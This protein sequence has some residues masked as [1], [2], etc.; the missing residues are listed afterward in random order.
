VLDPF[1]NEYGQRLYNLARKLCQN[2]ED[3]EDLYQ[4]TWIKA[5]RFFGRYDKTRDF[6]A[7]IASICVNTYRDMRRRQK[8]LSLLTVFR[9]NEEKDYALASVPAEQP[10]DYGNIRDAVNTLPEKLRMAV[11][12]HYFHDM[13]VNKTAQTLGIPAGTVK[14]HLHKART[15]LKGRLENDG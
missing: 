14:Y 4:E 7:W 2:R 12:L 1:I 3:A 13:D 9:T 5:Y 15:I 11:I 10:L 6:G 8:W